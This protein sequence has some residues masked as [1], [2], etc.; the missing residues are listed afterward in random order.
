[1]GFRTKL[2]YSDNR[3]IKQ[4]EQTFTDLIGGTV[5]GLPFSGLTSGVDS[6]NT[7]TTEEYVNLTGNTFSG[8][9]TTTI[10]TWS[11]SRIS[12][13]DSS[14]SAITPSNSGLTQD[15]G[16]IFTANTT[17]IIDGNTVNLSYSGVSI[18]GLVVTEMTEIAPSIYTGKTSI[19]FF[20][21]LSGGSLDYT[22]RT[23]WVDCTEIARTKKLIIT[24]NPQPGYVWTCSD[25]EGLGYWAPMVDDTNFY[26]TGSTLVGST[27]YF[28]RTDTLS[29]YTL[30]LSSLDVNDT[31]ITGMTFNP[32]NYQIISTRNDGFSTSPIDL[33]ILSADVTITGGTYD[34][35]TGIVTFTNNSGGTF[36]VSGFT[37]GM[38]DSYTTAA[39]LS[40]SSITFDN[41]INGSNFYNVDLTPLNR[42]SQTGITSTSVVDSISTGTT[43]AATWHYSVN[44]G[45]N[46]RAGTVVAGWL[47][48]NVV[49]TETFTTDIG[50][51]SA[52]TFDVNE[53]GGLIRLVA[54]A[55]S[56]TWTVKV[57]RLLI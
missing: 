28:D 37:S 3:Q 56:G 12:L 21:V 44:D 23:I 7:G 4:R 10:F 27:V 9:A 22:G 2:D 5:F 8:N 33:S 20:D 46:L 13:V 1:M 32:V 54:T 50:D 30:D 31:F 41:N 51:T 53:S 57:N 17:T 16:Y 43:E 36:D 39:T 52:V 49:Y 6:S 38:T 11:D 26:T 47:G 42:Y 45:T 55:S 24:E 19:D 25:S 34:I 15:S 40:G 48:S 18:E 14:L 29:A 35:D